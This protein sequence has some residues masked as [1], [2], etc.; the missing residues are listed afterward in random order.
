VTNFARSLAVASA[1][2]RGRA[3][4]NLV[5]AAITCTLTLLCVA[6]AGAV[7]T[8]VGG[9]SVGLQ[10]RNGTNVRGEGNPAKFKN[11][12]GTAVLHGTSVY[13]IYWDPET[14]F[15]THAEWLIKIDHFM[16]Q[17]GAASGSLDTIFSNLAQYRDRS[18][19]SAVNSIVFKGSYHDFVA[20]PAAGCSDPAPLETGAITCLTDA[21]LRAELQSFLVAHGL[22]KGM[23]T[24][25]HLITP[26]GVTVCL[27]AASEHCSDFSVSGAEAAKGER[28]SESYENSFCSYHAA[29]NPGKSVNGDANTILYAAIPWTAGALP[30]LSFS[31]GSKAY[32][33]AYDCQDGGWNYEGTKVKREEPRALTEGEEEVLEGKK[34]TPAEK[35]EIEKRVRLEGP[36][37]QEPNQEAKGELGDFTAG[38]ADLII[39]QIAQEQA[40]IV[41]DPLLASWQDEA[42]HE[43]TDICRNTYG[44]TVGGPVSGS[45]AADNETEA[46][47]ISNETVGDGRYYIA[48]VWSASSSHCEGGTG[49]FPRF[50]APNTVNVNEIVG[51]NGMGSTVGLIR[52]DAFGPSGPPTKTYANFTWNF[53]D[54]TEASGYAPGSPVCEAPWLSP[55]A[56]SVFHTY[57]HGGSYQVTLKITD[58]AGYSTTATEPL[59]V[60]GPPATPTTGGS[61]SGSGAGSGA[62][63]PGASTPGSGSGSGKGAAAPPGKPVAAAAVVSKSLKRALRNGLAVS[64]SVNEQVAGRFEVLMARSLAKRLHIGGTAATG[65]PLG[66]PPQ[67]VIAKAILVTTKGGHSTV[68]IKFSKQVAARLRHAG[69]APLMLRLVVRN[70]ASSNP[71]TTSV[72]SAITLAG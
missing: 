4:R 30:S 69:K 32:D 41:T 31:T 52:A 9:T 39:N 57:A 47:F 23:N 27:D 10:P 65:L 7:V 19:A 12:T 42:G 63:S 24:V 38:L 71:D 20:Y 68:H 26:P 50:T 72:L 54:G 64:Y 35:E 18:N 58:V 55:C 33:N 29:V 2:P 49:L 43:V 51:F 1:S 48:N 44:N 61:G 67:L 13:S 37:Q 22:P 21:Q 34:G 56:G 45:G 11:Q 25:Y 28:N 40:N 70:A 60:V 17:M 3:A 16:Q 62:G 8:T 59:T 66:T 15:H 46:G 5:L 36:H 14:V 53:G 6:P